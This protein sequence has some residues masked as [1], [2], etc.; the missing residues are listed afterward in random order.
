ME[1]APNFFPEQ[2]EGRVKAFD[3]ANLQQAATEAGDISQSN[4]GIKGVSKG[5]FDEN[6]DALFKEGSSHIQMGGRGNGDHHT[7][8]HTE[9]FC[10]GRQPAGAVL[11]CNRSALSLAR[12]D[13]GDKIGTGQSGKNP[14]VVLTQR[15]NSNHTNTNALHAA[16]TSSE[17]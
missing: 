7:I 16:L 10:R 15:A 6:G 3:V 11:L 2:F 17:D 4:G 5:L 13:D 9:Q 12:I 1:W 8:H 14:R